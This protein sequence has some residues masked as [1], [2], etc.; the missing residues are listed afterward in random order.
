ME[1]FQI[2][3]IEE[4][5]INAFPAIEREIYDGWILNFSGGYTYRANCIYPF[6]ASKYSLEEKISHCEEQYRELFMPVVYKMTS[7]IDSELDDLLEAQGYDIVKYVDIMCQELTDWEAHPWKAPD[8]NYEVVTMTAMDKEWIQGVT[9]LIGIPFRSMEKIQE[10]IYNRICLPVVCVKVKHE[11]RVVGT[12]L[13]VLERHYIGLYAIHVNKDYRR[14]G[15]A[16]KICSDIMERGR[17]MGATKAHLQVRQ[18]NTGAFAMYEKLGMKKVY[19][20]W[21]RMK[22]WPESRKIFD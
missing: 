1:K 16:M 20:Q 19:T 22:S 3:E 13:G 7:A 21:F 11:G 4:I 17:I 14:R 10:K 6:Y 5:L 2:G 18:G 15:L 9:R 8:E 12:G